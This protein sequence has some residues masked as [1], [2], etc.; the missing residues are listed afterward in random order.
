MPDPGGPPSGTR[1]NHVPYKKKK[2]H[3]QMLGRQRPA[4]LLRERGVEWRWSRGRVV[5]DGSRGIRGEI[6]GSPNRRN[7]VLVRN[8][9]N[10]FG[11]WDHLLY[12]LS[13]SL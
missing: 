5:T 8:E 12:L 4:R 11:A 7:R 1:E 10:K 2:S 6:L 3:E 9:L 13:F